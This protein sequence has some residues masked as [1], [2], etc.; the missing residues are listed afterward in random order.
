MSNIQ[1]AIR[2]IDEM[3]GNITGPFWEEPECSALR[4]IKKLLESEPALNQSGT[5]QEPGEFTKGFREL[6]EHDRLKN[7][8]KTGYLQSQTISKGFEACDRIDRLQAELSFTKQELGA[9]DLEIK[10]LKKQIKDEKIERLKGSCICMDCGKVIKV[11]EQ[12]K[13]LKECPKEQALKGE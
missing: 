7:Q 10:K 2:E 5:G 4:S 3:I 6:L 11:T 8:L 12:S 9:A 13:H 1:E